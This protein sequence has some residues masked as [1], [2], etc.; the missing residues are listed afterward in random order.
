MRAHVDMFPKV[1]F[2][3][4]LCGNG[5]N[6]HAC[7][8]V[9][10]TAGCVISSCGN[11]RNMRAC[12]DVFQT[13]GCVIL[14]CGNDRNMRGCVDVFQTIGCVISSCGNGSNMC[15]CVEAFQTAGCA[16]SSRGCCPQSRPGYMVPF[17]CLHVFLFCL[18][19]LTLVSYFSYAPHFN[20]KM[21]IRDSGLVGTLQP[22]SPVWSELWPVV[23]SA[24]KVWTWSFLCCPNV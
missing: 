20:I 13:A 15:A 23:C 5:R 3:I 4:S 18:S 7:V 17:F 14:S 24:I 12:V 16:V 8:Y 21:W 22:C 6:V 19:C 11:G 1:C 9:F 10:Q 2:I